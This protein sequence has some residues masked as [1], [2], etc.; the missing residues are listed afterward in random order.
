MDCQNFGAGEEFDMD[1]IC[2]IES[3][4]TA[5]RIE[6]IFSLRQPPLKDEGARAKPSDRRRPLDSGE[7]LG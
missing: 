5:E 2:E 1:D 3:S 7:R 4:G 6:G